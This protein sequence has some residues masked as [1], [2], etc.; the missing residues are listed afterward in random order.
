MKTK[1]RRNCQTK[2]QHGGKKWENVNNIMDLIEWLYFFLFG[3]FFTENQKENITKKVNSLDSERLKDLNNEL[4]ELVEGIPQNNGDRS[5]YHSKNTKKMEFNY[6]NSQS[7][8]SDC[9]RLCLLTMLSKWKTYPNSLYYFK[10]S[11]DKSLQTY[12]IVFLSKINEIAVN[13][14]GNNFFSISFKCQ[15][16]DVITIKTFENVYECSLLNEDEGINY[17]SFYKLYKN[18]I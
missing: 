5:D 10:Y 16:K 13:C 1:N 11:N 9:S 3:R 4:S 8:I 6:K 15:D 17:K 12:H 14:D 7:N 2:K 18:T